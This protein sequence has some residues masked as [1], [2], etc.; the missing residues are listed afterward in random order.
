MQIIKTTAR[1]RKQLLLPLSFAASL[2]WSQSKPV[3]EVIVQGVKDRLTQQGA[4]SDSLIKTEVISSDAISDMNAVT[5]SEALEG[6]PGVRINN[7]CSMCGVKRILLNGLKGEQTTILIDGLPSHTLISGFYAVD[8]LPA[9]GIDRID[10][11]RGAGASLTSPEA[12]GGTI[13]VITTEADENHL[14]L[15]LSGG[16][17]GYKKASVLATAVNEEMTTKATFIGQYDV[18]DQYDADDN[19]VSES[20]YLENSSLIARVSHDLTNKDNLTFRVAHI[21]SEIFGGPVLGESFADGKINSITDVLTRFDDVESDQ[22]FQDNNTQKDFVGKAWE[23]AEWIET[24]RDELS[25]TWLREIN[26][27]LNIKV[28]SSYAKHIQDSFYEGFDYR[29]EDEMIY[30][31]TQLNWVLNEAHLLTFG[32]DT[33][34]EQLSSA[35]LKGEQSPDYI[36]DAFEYSVTGFFTQDTWH[37]TDSLEA[38]IAVR[39]DQVRADFT[40]PA[41]PSVE[42]DETIVSPRVDVRYFHNDYWTSRFS[43]GQGYRAPL[44]FFESD[45]GILDGEKGFEIQIDGLE[46]SVSSTYALSYENAP[47]TMTASAAFTKVDNMATLSE[48]QEGVPLLTQL[49]EDASV[50]AT[51][52]AMG[53]QVTNDFG[54]DLILERFFYNHAFKGSYG[55]AP[56][57]KRITLNGD[58]DYKGWEVIGT[59]VWFGEKDLDDF[60]YEGFNQLDDQG[61]V[62]ESSKKKTEAPAYTVFNMK[63]SKALSDAITVYVG[64][65]NVFDTTQTGDGDSPLIFD[66]EGG[67]DVAYIYGGLRGRE[68]YAGLTWHL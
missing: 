46:R 51:D 18:R 60:G 21:R 48:T 3:E 15:D 41:K 42:I 68:A 26:E 38:A 29:A 16:E 5:L 37:V 35:S 24:E 66:A 63:V 56:T 22:L 45:H 2:S 55:V 7:E 65:N 52:I 1:W 25:L 20:P 44:S 27:S 10:V 49:D 59:L 30:G 32:L 62:I 31:F 28:A 34:H 58:W 11:A 54:V 9:T 12:I 50:V 23:T 13:N 43:A 36:S 14:E 33:R 61:G 4:L 67:Y 53:Y 64:A 8:A 40:D 19:K 47:F 17:N 39:V 6:A 57:D